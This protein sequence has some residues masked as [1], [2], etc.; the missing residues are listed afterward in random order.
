MI[1]NARFAKAIAANIS[2]IAKA[3]AEIKL[4][5]TGHWNPAKGG[6]TG[7]IADLQN[8]IKR[9]EQNIADYL[10]QPAIDVAL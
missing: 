6:R 9:S 2:S 5:E 8:K 4:I 10:M 7:Q 1:K 3:T